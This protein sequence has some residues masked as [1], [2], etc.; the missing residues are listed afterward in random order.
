MNGKQMENKISWYF[1]FIQ[2]YQMSFLIETQES[3]I[4]LTVSCMSMDS[5]NLTKFLKRMEE[6]WGD[7]LPHLNFY[8]Y[9][10]Y[11]RIQD[12]TEE[13]LIYEFYFREKK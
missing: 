13:I 2:H 10:G 7:T 12:M 8:F 6:D 11:D 3:E 5:F 9:L 1:E 4:G